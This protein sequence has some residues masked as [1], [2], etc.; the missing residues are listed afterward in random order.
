MD[1]I[2]EELKFVYIEC[3]VL[4]FTKMR[5]SIVLKP[6]LDLVRRPF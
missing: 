5:R 2:F 1:S 6:Q 3:G 4:Q